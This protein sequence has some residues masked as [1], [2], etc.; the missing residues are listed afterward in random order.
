[1]ANSLTT[2]Y[3]AVFQKKIYCIKTLNDI[4]FIEHLFIPMIIII[5]SNELKNNAQRRH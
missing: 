1:M 5:D 2:D 3:F 4:S